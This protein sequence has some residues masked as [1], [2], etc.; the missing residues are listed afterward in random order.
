MHNWP[1]HWGLGGSGEGLGDSWDLKGNCPKG[2][3]TAQL[4][5]IVPMWE[6]ESS[7]ARSFNDL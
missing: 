1:K 5:L 4:L 3:A 7:L 2:T 6:Y